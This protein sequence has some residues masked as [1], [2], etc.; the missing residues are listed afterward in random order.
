MKLGTKKYWGVSQ[1]KAKEWHRE[2]ADPNKWEEAMEARTGIML[3]GGKDPVMHHRSG[4]YVAYAYILG[5]IRHLGVAHIATVSKAARLHDSALYHL[6]GFFNN[7]QP[8]RFTLRTAEE[9]A[10]NPPEYSPEIKKLREKLIQELQQE[11]SNPADYDF[12]YSQF[13]AN[14]T[15]E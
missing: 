1:V 7:P 8:G 5:K 2:F 14:Q 10:I 13:L 11:G 3:E 6:W 12:N 15:H 9:Y 4:H